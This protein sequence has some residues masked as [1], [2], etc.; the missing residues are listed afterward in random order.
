MV[1]SEASLGFARFE[2]RVESCYFRVCEEVLPVALD[3]L[4]EEGED[5]HVT[6]FRSKMHDGAA[7]RKRLQKQG[8]QMDNSRFKSSALKSNCLG[9]ASP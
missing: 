2:R 3:R 1:L 8:L 5:R 6:S 4:G 9:F 7:T